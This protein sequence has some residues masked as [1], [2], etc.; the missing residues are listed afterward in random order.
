MRFQTELNFLHASF[1]SKKSLML[2]LFMALSVA[3]QIYWHKRSIILLSYNL[4]GF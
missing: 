4:N 2:I 1:I 3:K